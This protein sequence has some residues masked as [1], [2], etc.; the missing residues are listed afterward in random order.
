[1]DIQALD[2][3][4][5]G[6]RYIGGGK[7][8]RKINHMNF[9]SHFKRILSNLA[10]IVI[11]SHHWWSE[12]GPSS[13]REKLTYSFHALTEISPHLAAYCDARYS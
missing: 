9:Q 8:W 3:S 6:N 2:S 5:S 7:I 4:N 12:Q 11:L 10:S 13:L 1:M